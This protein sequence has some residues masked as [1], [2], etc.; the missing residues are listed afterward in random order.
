MTPT[1]GSICCSQ[2]VKALSTALMT[3]EMSSS[4]A[5]LRMSPNESS[6]CLTKLPMPMPSVFTFR[7]QM[8][9]MLSCSVTK[10]VVAAKISVPT[11]MAVATGPL[12]LQGEAGNA[13]LQ[14]FGR[15]GPDQALHLPVN[16]A[17]H[18]L[19]AIHCAGHGDDN[20][21]QRRQ[22]KNGV[23]RQRRRVPKRVVVAELAGRGLED[24]QTSENL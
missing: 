6:R 8:S 22:R 19:A 14:E 4:S 16:L 7:F 15:I 12:L 10:K 11:P 24:G 5:T 17:R 18:G 1:S 3:K 20:E 2:P 21:Q 23:V 9:L 13:V